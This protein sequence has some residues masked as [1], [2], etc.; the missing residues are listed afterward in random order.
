[1][2]N[3]KTKEKALKSDFFENFERA[4]AGVVAPCR[5]LPDDSDLD[6]IIF[7]TVTEALSFGASFE[8]LNTRSVV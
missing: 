8:A 4:R 2:K 6:L 3:M 5:C 1:M 7:D